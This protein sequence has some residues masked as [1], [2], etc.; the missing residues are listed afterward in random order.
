[1]CSSEGLGWASKKEKT[2]TSL[3]E[4]VKET[5][6]RGEISRLSLIV[7]LWGLSYS[8]DEHGV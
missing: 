5:G 2:L 7:T 1:V 4:R 6:V 8:S 3:A